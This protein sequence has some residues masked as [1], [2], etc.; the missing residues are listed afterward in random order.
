MSE[1]DKTEE[2]QIGDSIVL[3]FAVQQCGGKARLSTIL[4]FFEEHADKKGREF[5]KEDVK[6]EIFRMLGECCYKNLLG[7]DSRG[8]YL[9][10]SG[11][12]ELDA[13]ISRCRSEA[14]SWNRAE[15]LL[16]LQSELRYQPTYGQVAPHQSA[17]GLSYPYD[18]GCDNSKIYDNAWED[19]F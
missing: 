10:K 19:Q 2:F 14:A 18:V 1:R 6:P 5:R 8:I 15:T 7:A 17:D 16:D 3:L 13:E 11:K 9:T 12:W 4:N